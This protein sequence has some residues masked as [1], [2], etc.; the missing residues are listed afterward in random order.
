M[1]TKLSHAREM[2]KEKDKPKTHEEKGM[3][4]ERREKGEGKNREDHRGGR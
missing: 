3:Q 4:K 1:M 2:L